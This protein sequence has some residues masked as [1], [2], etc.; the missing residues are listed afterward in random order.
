[1]EKVLKKPAKNSLEARSS[2]QPHQLLRDAFDHGDHQQH[3]REGHGPGQQPG[4]GPGG[5]GRAAPAQGAHQVHHADDAGHHSGHQ[6]WHD[7]QGVL[8]RQL[9]NAADDVGRGCRHRPVSIRAAGGNR[10]P[11]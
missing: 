3:R 10:A 2:L 5:Q 8:G 4:A 6:Q 1:M 9:G 11:D 7:D